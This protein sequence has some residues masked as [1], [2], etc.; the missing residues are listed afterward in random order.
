MK[1]KIVLYRSEEGITVGV[2]ALPGCWSEG[3]TEEE[4][5]INIQD[6]IRE[7]LAALEERWQDGEIPEI[8]MQV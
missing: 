3:D 8:K 4:A 2:P 1:Y 5:L 7:Y 6:A